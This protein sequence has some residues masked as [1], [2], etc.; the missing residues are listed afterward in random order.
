VCERERER[1]REREDFLSGTMIWLLLPFLLLHDYLYPLKERIRYWVAE[2]KARRK[3]LWSFEC[4]IFVLCFV[5]FPFFLTLIPLLT[6][7]KKNK[8]I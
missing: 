8:S 1:E 3:N 5:M 2:G 4:E 7:V 6:L